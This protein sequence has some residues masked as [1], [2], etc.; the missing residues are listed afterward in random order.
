MIE[1]SSFLQREEFIHIQQE[2]KKVRIQKSACS[3]NAFSLSS[4][5]THYE[6]FHSDIIKAIL[7]PHGS[8][9]EGNLFLELFIE[10]LNTHYNLDLNVADYFDAKV[11]RENGRIDIG[12]RSWEKS[13]A[14]II[15]NK[16]NNA[17]DM[18]NQLLRYYKHCIDSGLQVHLIIYLS[19]DGLKKAPLFTDINCN[20]EIAA[21]NN[22]P[23]DLASGWL[24][25]C[26]MQ[27]S[28]PNTQSLLNEYYKL[29][30][31]LNG[32]AMEKSAFENFYQII[33]ED[34]GLNN[35]ENIVQFYN[36][37]PRFRMDKFVQRVDKNYEPFTKQY[38]YRQNYQLYENYVVE[39]HKFKL[40]VWFEQSG[41][42][43]IVFWDGNDLNWR[44]DTRTI[45][46]QKLESVNI[47]QEFK[48]S[49]CGSNGYIKTFS[50]SE[51]GTLK[52]IDDTVFEFVM[53]LLKSL[54]PDR[55]DLQSVQ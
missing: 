1:T 7:D 21:F 5:N 17:P 15:E 2:L 35:V 55:V 44:D 13:K 46:K 16:I 3:F 42:A 31:H 28:E 25:K 12:I 33:N 39:I 11:E 23:N 26:I 24:K 34:N 45:V 29:L 30:Q 49:H 48:E 9:R 19:M 37:L 54:Q 8:H 53:R 38:R 40:D 43:N 18:D 22:T 10:F 6:N 20:I 4:Y 41:T 32:Q 36:E 51:Y 50:L 47:L 52:T 27:S 14:I